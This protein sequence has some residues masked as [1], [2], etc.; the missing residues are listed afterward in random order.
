MNDKIIKRGRPKKDNSNSVK[1]T[2]RVTAEH[3]EKILNY[4]K[5]NNLN[6]SQG[7]R[8]AIENLPNE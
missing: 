1:L 4:C 5:K 3:N 7:V 8:K 6:L 2:V